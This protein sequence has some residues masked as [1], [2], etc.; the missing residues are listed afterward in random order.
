MFVGPVDRNG[1]QRRQDQLRGAEA[2][3]EGG[4]D[5]GHPRLP[6]L[7]PSLLEGPPL[8]GHVPLLRHQGAGQ[9]GRVQLDAKQEKPKKL[10]FDDDI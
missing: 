7:Q 1:E 4:K 3:A 5:G 10:A 2:G 9:Q 6:P 8:R